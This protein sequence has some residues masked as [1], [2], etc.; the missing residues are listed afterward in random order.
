MIRACFNPEIDLKATKMAF[1]ANSPGGIFSKVVFM[2][3]PMDDYHP[4]PFIS[5]LLF[6]L[7]RDISSHLW[8]YNKKDRVNE[9]R[10][11]SS[12]S[13]LL[14]RAGEEEGARKRTRVDSSYEI[15]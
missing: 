7:P 3:V 14:A 4:L 11:V 1:M 13:P 6:D 5:C 9:G 8:D 10:R 12:K 2:L 15:P